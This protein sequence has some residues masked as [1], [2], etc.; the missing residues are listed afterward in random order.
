MQ[1]KLRHKKKIK[2]TNPVYRNTET[3]TART[4]D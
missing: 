2:S 1:H 3:E 4:A